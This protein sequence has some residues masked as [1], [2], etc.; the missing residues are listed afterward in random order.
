MKRDGL[1]GWVGLGCF[2]FLIFELIWFVNFCLL[3][4]DKFTCIGFINYN[5]FGLFYSNTL[6][7]N[8]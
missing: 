4:G 1:G 8:W 5:Y 6:A 7:E 3:Q 2:V